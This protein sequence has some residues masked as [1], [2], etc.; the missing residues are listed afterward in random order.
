MI[1]NSPSLDQHDSQNQ[2]TYS[3]SQCFLERLIKESEQFGKFWL[4]GKKDL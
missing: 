1:I 4:A 3:S 2:S